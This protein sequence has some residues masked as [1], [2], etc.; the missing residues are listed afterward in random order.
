MS[1]RFEHL[2]Q[3]TRSLRPSA[4]VGV[5]IALVLAMG[6]VTAFYTVPAESEGVVL[7]FGRFIDTVPSGLHFKVPFGIDQ[8]EIV[9]VK[10]QLKQEFGFG[11]R[12][13]TNPWQATSQNEWGDEKSMVTGDL[14]AAVVEWVVQYRIERPENY[15]FKV[16]NADAT[17]RDA[18]ESVM[19]EVVGDRT[20][21]EVITV[22]RQEIED[23]ALQRLQALVATYTMG[24]K[25]DQVQLKNVN[26]PERVQ[27]S[28]NEVNQAQQERERAINIA[29]GEYN[30]AVP[31]ARGEADQRISAAQG[32]AKQRVNEAQGDVA[33]FTA[34]LAE[35]VKAP[36]VTRR[37]LYLET[38][39]KVLS[40]VR[41]KVILDDDAGGILPLLNLDRI[42]KPDAGGGRLMT[43]RPPHVLGLVVLLVGIVALAASAYTVTETQQVILTQFGKP[44][45]EPV[46]DAGLHFKVPFIQ[47][48]NRIDKRILEWDG[49]RTEMPTRDKLYISVDTFGRW[50]ITN[51]LEYFRRLRDERSAQSR[52]EDILGSETR[53][54]I[55]KHDLVEVV[56]TTKDRVPT[57]DETIQEL[58]EASGAIGV[59]Q[60]IDKGRKKIE[61]EIRTAAK[62][63]LAEFGI[64]LLD[65]R[66]KRINYNPS[67]VEKIYERMISERQQIASR[68]RSEGEGEAAKILG[69]KERDLSEISS[70]AYKAVEEIR[71]AADA[72]ATEIYALAYDQTPESRDLYTFLKTMDTYDKVLG[73]DTTLVLS[74]DSELFRYLSSA[75]G[76]LE[77]KADSE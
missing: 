52:L 35:Y 31:R 28:F 36:E 22:G 18:S 27:A 11:T 59:L 15:L 72:R 16:R 44:I 55:A 70:E 4:L 73:P 2:T 38:M 66:F 54:A 17:L 67:V 10:R 26:P 19:R 57:R 47:E 64:E 9:P 40:R 6:A 63:K 76:R 51:P 39:A 49:Q 53:N 56:R 24:I 30:K 50:R 58:T 74:T 60:P 43:I 3:R 7:R 34:L 13:A 42:E 8:V 46:T 61:E 32:Y 33:A 75:V 65:V 12:G 71:G 69:K 23:E 48:V 68:F 41:S 62:A 45:G 37:R 25:I 77:A 14:N 1:S 20:V 29:N 21:D 5:G